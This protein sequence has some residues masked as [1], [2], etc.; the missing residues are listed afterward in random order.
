MSYVNFRCDCGEQFR[1]KKFFKMSYNG[2]FQCY[3][4]TCPSC[5]KGVESQN[6]KP[7]I[8]GARNTY[9]P[10]RKDRDRPPVIPANL[11]KLL[12]K[13]KEYKKER[14]NGKS[15][16]ERGTAEGDGS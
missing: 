15:E 14:E 5:K 3:K 9:A 2:E 8:P 12:D 10:N 1:T 16:V 6:E 4:T 11:S 7:I 13:E